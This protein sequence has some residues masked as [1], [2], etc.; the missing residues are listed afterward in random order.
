M[1]MHT[2]LQTAAWLLAQY[3]FPFNQVSLIRKITAIDLN[4]NSTAQRAVHQYE[5]ST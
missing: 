3:V 5:A 2:E 4:K 1:E